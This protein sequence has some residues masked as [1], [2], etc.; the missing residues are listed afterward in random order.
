[1]KKILIILACSLLS[2]SMK[3]QNL[4]NNWSF[5]DTIQCINYYGQIDS[6][7]GWNSYSQ[8]PDYF[9]SCSS[10]MGVPFNDVGFQYARTGNAYAGFI[11]FA[12]YASNYRE[13]IGTQLIQSLIIG[14][15]YFVTFYVSRAY[16]TTNPS[17]N[18]K[19]VNGASNKIGARFSTVQ[20]SA[21]N[22]VPIDNFAQVYSDSV[23]TD[24]LNW[25]KISGSF[26]ADSTYQYVCF[27]NF[28]NDT[29]TTHILFDTTAS[30]T[31]YYIDDA[32]VSIDSL[33]TSLNDFSYSF[34]QIK[35]IPN[36]AKDWIAIDGSDLKS[37]SIFDILGRKYIE[38]VF[39]PTSLKSI[40]IGNLSKGIYFI[41]TNTL[42]QSSTQKLIIQ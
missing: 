32:I 5:E 20:Y 28:F 8:S 4:V 36:P 30:C 15:K 38:D 2:P 14:Q 10:L 31:Y 29:V 16:D 39:V 40:Y 11:T 12:R 42:K 41:Q 17:F 25:V 18:A 33:F 35:I 23:I 13:V 7:L 3:A 21:N 6:C 9:N 24:T 37:V 1:M 34:Q 27:G 26:I 19:H 22:P